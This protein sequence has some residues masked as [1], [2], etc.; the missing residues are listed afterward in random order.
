MNIRN[1]EKAFTILKSIAEKSNNKAHKSYY[2]NFIEN[3][4]LISKEL[5]YNV[6]VVDKSSNIVDTASHIK[7]Y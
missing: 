2:D 4:S 6:Y 7:K 3:I 1:P 5:L